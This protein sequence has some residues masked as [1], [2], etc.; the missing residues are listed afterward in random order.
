MLDGREL[1]HA[2]VHVPQ[3]GLV[4]DDIIPEQNFHLGDGGIQH[5]L[6]THLDDLGGPGLVAEGDGGHQGHGDGLVDGLGGDLTGGGNGQVGGIPLVGQIPDNTGSGHRNGGRAFVQ[7]FLQVQ[8]AALAADQVESAVFGDGDVLCQ[9]HGIEGHLANGAAAVVGGGQD[10][11]ITGL[12]HE[13]DIDLAAGAVGLHPGDGAVGRGPGNTGE[14][15]FRGN[16]GGNGLLGLIVQVGLLA[17]DHVQVEGH[18]LIGDDLLVHHNV[19]SSGPGVDMD[20]PGD[21]AGGAVQAVVVAGDGDGAQLGNL[22]AGDGDGA[23]L[24]DDGGVGFVALVQ[25]PLPVELECS[26]LHNGSQG[27]AVG[28]PDVGLLRLLVGIGVV[29]VVVLGQG[30]VHGFQSQLFGQGFLRQ[31]LL[32]GFFGQGLS[33]GFLSD[34][35]GF[36]GEGFGGFRG[37]FYGFLGGN[38]GFLHDFLGG[39]GGFFG[40]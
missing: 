35:D 36:L 7:G 20:F 26:G 37:F 12:A 19:D 1:Q 33:H 21:F 24:G 25:V 15:I 22:C 3:D 40:G 10:V 16:D 17:H 6:V 31:G 11:H 13:L 32:G 14:V 28:A 5:D 39:S 38:S 23:A 29:L 18:D 27:D 34:G 4:I 30:E 9:A 8:G 2:V